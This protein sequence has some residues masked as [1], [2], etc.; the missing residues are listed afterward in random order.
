MQTAQPDSLLDTEESNRPVIPKDLTVTNIFAPVDDRRREIPAVEFRNVSFAYNDGDRPVLQNVSFK[1]MKGEMLIVLGGS[2]TG[3]S[4]VLRLAIGLNK[5]DAGQILIDGEDITNYDEE[6]L[7]KVRLG[8]GMDFQGGALFDSLSVYDNV[9][10][11]PH[12]RGV[13]DEVIEEQIYR[14]LR[15]LNIEDAIDMLPAELSGGMRIRVGLARSLIN[16]P[17][18]VLLDEPTAGLDPPTATSVCEL[19]IWLR[20]LLDVATIVVTHSLE[21]VRYMASTY[22]VIT[23]DRRALLQEEGNRLCVVNTRIMM[24]RE[25]GVIFYGTDEQLLKS[26]DPYVRRFLLL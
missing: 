26:E 5:P 3:K 8:I 13:P 4:T 6:A 18:I 23:P 19:S 14:V 12:D 11:S 17:H 15:F 7:N 20:D 9:A 10:Y 21:S 24:L 2:G 25:G 22:A 1:L 16:Q